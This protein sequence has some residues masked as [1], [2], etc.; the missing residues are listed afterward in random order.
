MGKIWIL[1][2]EIILSSKLLS[3]YICVK[4]HMGFPEINYVERI[5]TKVIFNASYF[6]YK[7]WE[8]VGWNN[9]NFWHPH[10]QLFSSSYTPLYNFLAFSSPPPPIKGKIEPPLH[11]FHKSPYNNYKNDTHLYKNSLTFCG[12]NLEHRV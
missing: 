9:R 2:L 6:M 1:K 3:T 10:I 12:P 5:M 11:P 8:E 7:Y 4:K